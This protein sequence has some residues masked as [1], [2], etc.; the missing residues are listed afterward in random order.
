MGSAK[1]FLDEGREHIENVVLPPRD[2]RRA[3]EAVEA[4]ATRISQ[5]GRGQ[6]ETTQE[7][8]QEE[9]E[10]ATRI[11]TTGEESVDDVLARMRNGELS[12]REAAK[13]VAEMRREL[14]SGREALKNAV[15][16]EESTW[17][18]V[19]T[20]PAAYQRALAHRAPQLFKG[21]KGLLE[22]PTAD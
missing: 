14:N 22:L 15:A 20:D 11:S 10:F 2:H 12:P 5:V 21:G 7:H 6:Y 1:F 4:E 13:A 3:S 17:A 9:V 8:F 18:E 16:R 19:N